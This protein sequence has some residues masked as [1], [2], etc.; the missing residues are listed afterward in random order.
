[1][2]MKELVRV[3]FREGVNIPGD[4]MVLPD[5]S[6]RLVGPNT[7]PVLPQR[8]GMGVR[9]VYKLFWSEGFVVVEHPVSHVKMRYPA[10]MVR[11]MTFAEDVP[12]KP[13]EAAKP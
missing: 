4:G 6:R 7:E 12:S 5:G 3:Q 13:V 9:M 11:E 8:T 1:M 2:A 10:S